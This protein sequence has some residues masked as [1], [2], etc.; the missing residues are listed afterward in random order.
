LEV[1]EHE[2]NLGLDVSVRYGVDLILSQFDRTIVVEDD[3]RVAPEFYRFMTKCLARYENDLEVAAVT[4]FRH[5][6][7]RPALD[8]HPYDVFFTRRFSSW[9]WATWRRFWRSVTFDDAE[10][11]R[12]LEQN[13]VDPRVAGSDMKSMIESYLSGRITQTWAIPVSANVLLNGQ[14]VV[15][16]CWNMV[17]NLGLQ[18]GTHYSEPPPWTSVWEPEFAPP[19]ES[20]RL[21]EVTFHNAEVDRAFLDFFRTYDPEGWRRMLRVARNWVAR[22]LPA[23]VRSFLR[24]VRE[25]LRVR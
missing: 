19:L 8:R 25:R 13:R 5:P 17:E 2:E 23:A 1:L 21:P 18:E 16:P 9:G 14:L 11:T 3:V 22:R 24:T 15:Y 10:I 7:T 6:F 12:R 20:L 4:G